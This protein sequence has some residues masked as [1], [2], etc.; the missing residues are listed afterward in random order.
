MWDSDTASP[1]FAG[2]VY[3]DY[4][5]ER[6]KFRWDNAS[7][8]VFRR[9]YGKPETQSSYESHLF[10]DAESTGKLITRDE[11]YRD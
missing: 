10:R 3:L 4:P 9:F 2:E 1:D 11:Y 6:V 7:E 5:F 8:K